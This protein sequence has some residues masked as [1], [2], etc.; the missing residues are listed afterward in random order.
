[1]GGVMS[2]EDAAGATGVTGR[3]RLR[4][5]TCASSQ[6]PHGAVSAV[7]A[8]LRAG[9]LCRRIGCEREARRLRELWIDVDV[10]AAW[11]ATLHE[12][13]AHLRRRVRRVA[14]LIARRLRIA[15]HDV[16]P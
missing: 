16:V 9:A 3:A 4:A 10:A 11:H 14:H 13:V 2:N 5:A 7:G 6:R 15:P 12:V 8:E 1:M